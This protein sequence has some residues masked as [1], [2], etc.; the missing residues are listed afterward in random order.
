MDAR[1]GSAPNFLAAIDAFR[2][3]REDSRRNHLAD[4][5]ERT[6]EAQGRALT[7]DTAAQN[8]LAR[9]SPEAYMQTRQFSDAQK[10]QFVEDFTRR[11]Y[12]ANTPQKWQAMIDG[13]RAE[14]RSFGDG[15]DA[16]ENRDALIA[17]G[18]DVGD[19][20]GMDLRREESGRAQANADRS[21]GL[22]EQNFK[23]DEA[24]RA[25]QIKIERAKLGAQSPDL[26]ELYD[27]K[28]GQPFKARY[29]SQT[30]GFDRVGG[31]KAPS[32]TSLEVG[33]DGQVSF[34]QGMGKPLTEGQ[35]KDVVFTTRAAGALQQL[36]EN[37]DALTSLPE[38]LGG[39]VPVVGN[40]AKSAKF[41]QA[42]QAG[43]EFLQAILRKDT[44]AAITK[45]EDAEYGVVYL[46]RPGDSKR[47]LAQKRASRRRALQALKLGLPPRAILDMEKA[48]VDL[49]AANNPDEPSSPQTGKTRRGISFELGE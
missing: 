14:G 45:E 24:Y 16:W 27:D 28:T 2:Q 12:A 37:S 42:E 17:R 41:Q 1:Y 49:S 39:Q 5:A 15:E 11:A 29:N 3:G 47:V 32:G 4:L 9:L 44:G 10:K 40:Y 26:V 8:E 48:G 25:E 22:Q 34:T 13:Y 23:A 38:T 30:G 18:L 19:M 20:M 36:E 43:K 46:P 35:S 21:Y 31:V 6:R 33:P 7:G